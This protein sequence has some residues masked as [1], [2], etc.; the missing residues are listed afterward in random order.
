MFGRAMGAAALAALLAAAPAARSDT[1]GIGRLNYAGYR[2]AQ[3]CT[4]FAVVGGHLVTARHCLDVPDEAKLHYL[5]AYDRGG[6][7]QHIVLSPA[8]F[9]PADAPDVA[10]ACNV[11]PPEAPGLRVAEDAPAADDTLEVWGYGAPRAEVL[12]R[13][14]CAL[15]GVNGN[16]T[17]VLSCATRGGSSGGPVVRRRGDTL[18]A[19]GVAWASGPD[20]TL[21]TPL[22]PR[23]VDDVCQ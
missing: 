2:V 5:D 8:S 1:P 13:I 7:A 16:G 4:A 9:A 22:S 14:P 21:A 6:W 23:Q 18:E 11:G 15:K 10:L 3:H 12:Q 20:M 17:L 19:I